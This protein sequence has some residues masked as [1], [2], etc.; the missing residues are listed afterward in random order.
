MLPLL[1]RGNTNPNKARPVRNLDALQLG[2]QIGSEVMG[3]EQWKKYI[4]TSVKEMNT[5]DKPTSKPVST[6][7]AA[8]RPSDER[9]G[10]V[11]HHIALTASR[12]AM[13]DEITSTLPGHTKENPST[14]VESLREAI[15]EAYHLN[16][17]RHCA[18]RNKDQKDKDADSQLSRSSKNTRK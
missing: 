6:K 4:K 13:T 2:E 7:L 10:W 18:A 16:W 5:A 8:A 17:A 11:F 15:S 1:S 12:W 3:Q 9:K 14:H